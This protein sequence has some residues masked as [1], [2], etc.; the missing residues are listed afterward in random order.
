MSA[1]VYS[2]TI[3]IFELFSGIDPFSGDHSQVIQAKTTDK[4]PPIPSDFPLLL[5]ELMLSGWSKDPKERSSIEEFK[6]ALKKMLTGDERDHSLTLPVR[7]FST[8]QPAPEVNLALEGRSRL[9]TI[10]PV[11]T[12]QLQTNVKAG[13][14]NFNLL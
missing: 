13:K 14:Y 4:K 12:E 6:S 8:E 2:L 11:T 3:I 7:N 5:I 10:P 1:D 9:E